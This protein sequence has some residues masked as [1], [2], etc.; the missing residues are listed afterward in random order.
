MAIERLNKLGGKADVKSA[1]SIIEE[2]LNEDGE[3]EDEDEVKNDEAIA[4]LESA[5]S[6]ATLP[7][8]P[9]VPLTEGTAMVDST[10]S[11]SLRAPHDDTPRN[12]DTKI[13]EVNVSIQD[14]VKA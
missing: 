6:E 3:D 7:K 8:H 10:S 9:S 5:A 1:Q 4:A 11:D 12:G 13:D 14:D 2:G